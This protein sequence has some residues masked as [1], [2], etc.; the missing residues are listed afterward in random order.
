MRSKPGTGLLAERNKQALTVLRS[1][2]KT[3]LF[4]TFTYVAFLKITPIT[5]EAVEPKSCKIIRN[6]N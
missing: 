2:A 5:E 4:Y 6:Y 1:Q 3:D